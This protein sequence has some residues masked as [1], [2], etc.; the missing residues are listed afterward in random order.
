M[1]QIPD[2]IEKFVCAAEDSV[3]IKCAV[4][5]RFFNQIQQFFLFNSCNERFIRNA[6]LLTPVFKSGSALVRFTGSTRSVSGEKQIFAAE[7]NKFRGC[8]LTA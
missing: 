1:K 5:Q 8:D 4:F 2:L 6:V 3:K 7:L